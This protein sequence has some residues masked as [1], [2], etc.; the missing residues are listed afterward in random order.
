MNY[1]R[2]TEVV[3]LRSHQ[4]WRQCC[5]LTSCEHR[6]TITDHEVITSVPRDP[7][8][9]FMRSVSTLQFQLFLLVSWQSKKC[10]CCCRAA[11]VDGVA[12]PPV[13]TLLQHACTQL[14]SGSAKSALRA[15]NMSLDACWEQLHTGDWK[16]VTY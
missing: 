16:E 9:S 3:T 4:V 1:H 5:V 14:M 8:S 2:L 10:L 7:E 11:D 15:A 12:G 6:L 13:A